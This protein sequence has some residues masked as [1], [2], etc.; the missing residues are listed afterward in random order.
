MYPIKVDEN[1][2]TNQLVHIKE[3]LPYGIEGA[4]TYQQL[5]LFDDMNFIP[6]QQVEEIL[7]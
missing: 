1:Y 3:R 4:A 2:I 5:S 6:N 7:L